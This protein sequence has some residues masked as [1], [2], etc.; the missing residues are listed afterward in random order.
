MA[1]LGIRW[2][3]R[4]RSWPAIYDEYQLLEVGRA[5]NSDLFTIARRLLRLSEEATKPNAERLREYAEAGLDSLKQQ[6]FSEAP[7][8]PDLE[9]V[10]LADSLSMLMEIEGADDP[11]VQKVLAGKSPRE[12]AAELVAGSKLADVALRKQLADGGGC[13]DREIG[14]PDDRAGTPG[15]RSVAESPPHL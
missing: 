10:K 2:P 7:I 9:V 4:S 1:T 11:L 14:R 6:L 15:R 5:F 12:R 8:Y 13:G 3:V